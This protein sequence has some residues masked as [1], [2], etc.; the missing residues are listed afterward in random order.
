MLLWTA[1]L[2][3]RMAHDFPKMGSHE[4]SFGSDPI[5][6]QEEVGQSHHL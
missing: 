5:E 6:G 1:L 4:G 3:E 2:G